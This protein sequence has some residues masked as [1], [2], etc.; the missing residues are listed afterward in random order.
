MVISLW[1][2][3]PRRPR[4]WLAQ[5]WRLQ[6][7]RLW[8][9]S[10]ARTGLLHWMIGLFKGSLVRTL[11]SY[12]RMSRGS[13]DIMSSSCH[14]V[15]VSSCHHHQWLI[16]HH[17]V[18]M[19]SC[20]QHSEQEHFVCG[21]RRRESKF[22]KAWIHGWKHYPARNPVFFRVMWPLRS[23]KY[24]VSVS[25]GAGLDLGKLSTKSAQD[26]PGL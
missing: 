22:G 1:T 14:H 7:M 11:P 5:M 15:I 24:R 9:R 17:H 19:S 23:P 4:P 26:C 21:S 8:R 13:L 16:S 3:F 2:C 6:G 20:Q 12:R 25:A 18:I 10:W